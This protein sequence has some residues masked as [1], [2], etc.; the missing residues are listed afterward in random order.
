MSNY[1]GF[2]LSGGT[3][4]WN[5]QET[6]IR[7]SGGNSVGTIVF[8]LK[9][10]FNSSETSD[11]DIFTIGTTGPKLSFEGSNNQIRFYPDQT[12]AT[13]YYQVDSSVIVF[14]GILRLH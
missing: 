8:P 4:I 6:E 12:D 3:L 5:L 14:C 1:Y 7:W 2:I 11:F 10:Y 9:P 13:H